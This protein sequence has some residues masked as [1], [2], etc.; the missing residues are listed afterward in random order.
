[1]TD[2]KSEFDPNKKVDTIPLKSVINIK[3]SGFYYARVLQLVVNYVQQHNLNVVELVA[4]L[5]KR[6]PQNNIEY[7][8]ITLISL[9]EEIQREAGNQN[10]TVERTVNEILAAQK[11]APG[12]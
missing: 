12:S 6:E 10:I 2:T 11:N 9:T 1:M 8:F 7:D 5:S 3:V 4:E